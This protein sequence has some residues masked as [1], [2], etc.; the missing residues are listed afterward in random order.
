M[1]GNAVWQQLIS[2]RLDTQ[3]LLMRM[4]LREM[5]VEML[6]EMW[7]HFLFVGPLF[8]DWIKVNNYLLIFLHRWNDALVFIGF[9]RSRI[10]TI[11]QNIALTFFYFVGSVVFVS[12]FRFPI[13]LKLLTITAGGNVRCRWY[14][15]FWGSME[16][17]FSILFGNSKRYINL[18]MRSVVLKNPANWNFILGVLLLVIGIR[19]AIGNWLNH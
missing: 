15:S 17:W 18:P 13:F 5:G 3:V 19:G 9:I 12:V 1:C 7:V 4:P 6:M 16:S 10:L 11:W 8:F 14:G 2:A